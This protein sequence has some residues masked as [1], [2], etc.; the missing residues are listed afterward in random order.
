VL[1]ALGVVLALGVIPANAARS[2][3]ERGRSALVEGQDALLEGEGSVAVAEFER[4]EVAFAAAGND[5]RSPFLRIAGFFPLLGRTPNAVRELADAGREV[6]AAGVAIGRSIDALPDGLE[7]LGPRQG[8]VAIDSYERLRAPLREASNHLQQA[9]HIIDRVETSWLLGPV[10]DAREEFESRLEPLADSLAAGAIIVDRLPEFLGASGPRQY[11]FVAENPAELRGTGGLVG[12][13]AVMRAVDGRLEFGPFEP[14]SAFP[15]LPRGRVLPPNPDYARRYPDA[16]RLI[17]VINL[18]PDFPSA[19]VALE[20]LYEASRGVEVDGVISADPSAMELMLAVSGPVSVPVLG[21][22]SSG[23]VVSLVTNQ[24]YALLPDD[25]ARK[26]LIGL[27]AQLVLG[28]FL[29]GADPAAA[30]EGIGAAAGSGHLKIFVHDDELQRGLVLAGVA[31]ALPQDAGQVVFPVVNNGAAN[32]IDFY[33]DRSL[34]FRVAL[35]AE[36]RARAELRMTIDNGAPSSGQPSYVIGPGIREAAPGENIS[37]VSMFLSAGTKLLEYQRDGAVEGIGEDSELGYTVLESSLSIPSGERATLRYELSSDSAWTGSTSDG[38]YRLAL[39]GQPT[40]RNTQM[41]VEVVAPEGTRIVRHSEGMRV[42]GNRAIWDG[43]A[44]GGE[45][46]FEIEFQKPVLS[47]G[48]DA[49][50][51]FLSRKLFT[52]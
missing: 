4:A 28:R 5:A 14:D 47:R 49:L 32:K 15:K 25:A 36:H 34:D 10:A 29:E 23:N 45:Q 37:I 38:R 12:S 48:W 3:L 41:H 46:V 39:V 40:I 27:I 18:T 51:R 11:L 33:A 8:R 9:R 2:N 35:G 7:S 31:G 44:S 24:A 1:V 16:N 50:M 22:V 43:S 30:A 42:D 13:V 20:R 19:A 26:R 6:A 52:F 17:S 21:E